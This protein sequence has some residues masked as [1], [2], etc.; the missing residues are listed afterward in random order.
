MALGTIVRSLTILVGSATAVLAS[1]VLA[2]ALPAMAAAFGNVENADFLVR[3]TFTMPALSIAVGALFSGILLD[4][5]GRK[6]V[7]MAS[8]ILYSVA[9]TSGFFLDSLLLILVGRVFLGLAVSGVISGFTTLITDYFSGGRLDRFMGYQAAAIGVGAMISLSLAGYLADID[10][11]L[12]FLLHLSAL[13]VIPGVWF[14]VD[15]PV[16][17]QR[18]SHRQNPSRQTALPLG[19]LA[20]P[21][22]A[23][24]AGMF[25][26]FV[27]PVLLPFHLTNQ[28][29]PTNSQIGFALSLQTLSSVISA[30]S[31]ERLR[32]RLTFQ[33]VLALTFLAFGVNHLIVAITP[34]YS[35]VT[36]ALLVGG[37]GIGV[38]PPNL[39]VW[40]ASIAPP[41]KRGQAVANLV[42]FV[43]L[44][45]FFAPILTQPAVASAG[46]AVTF[47]GIAGVS[48]FLAVIFARGRH[49]YH[50]QVTSPL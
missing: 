3:L 37:L 23:G 36:I 24:F 21:Y 5:W 4:R 15:E 48:L 12:P 7:L 9:G 30:L 31:Y 13:V 2:P 40:I 34:L 20:A 47:G 29:S 1:I 14:S 44:G 43:F 41:E 17:P 28:G 33:A 19:A 45:Q 35:F 22:G 18:V 16:R 6:P 8:L 25:V 42:T 26:F 39:N 49:S 46:A 32:R 38:L 27:F 50:D 10:W 11:R